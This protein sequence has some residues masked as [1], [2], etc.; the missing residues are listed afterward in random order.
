MQYLPV[1]LSLGMFYL[2]LL[3]LS[4]HIG[5]TAAWI[6]ASLVGALMNVICNVRR[7]RQ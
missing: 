7:C 4:E 1:G 5:F 2:L 6:T 3:A